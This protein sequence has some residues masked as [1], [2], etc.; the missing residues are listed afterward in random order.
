MNVSFKSFIV[1]A[2][3]SSAL[4]VPALNA[5]Q[6]LPST[7]QEAERVFQQFCAKHA[8][9]ALYQKG[10]FLAAELIDALQAML[11]GNSNKIHLIE[12][13]MMTMPE[14]R[15]FSV[16]YKKLTNLSTQLAQNQPIVCDY[17]LLNECSNAFEEAFF[18][19]C[20][21]VAKMDQAHKEHKFD[22]LTNYVRSQPNGNTYYT[23]LIMLLDTYKVLIPR[24]GKLYS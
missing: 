11:N 6:P 7:K 9:N 1:S 19:V 5:H 17:Q 13:K 14:L 16:P 3:I 2:C 12:Q 8:H 10:S 18:V 24:L 21:F 23:N 15:R 20:G 4:L 22:A